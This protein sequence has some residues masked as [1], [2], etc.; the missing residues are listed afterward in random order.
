MSTKD[1]T[2][3]ASTKKTADLFD[4]IFTS[5]ERLF[6]R[7]VWSEAD[8]IRSLQA[9]LSP[10][11]HDLTLTSTGDEINAKIYRLN[12]DGLL[13]RLSTGYIDDPLE[14]S[15]LMKQGKTPLSKRFFDTQVNALE[16][17]ISENI[18]RVNSPISLSETL[19][20]AS[21]LSLIEGETKKARE[22]VIASMVALKFPRQKDA[23]IE[24]YN[25]DLDK[26]TPCATKEHIDTFN[27][28]NQRFIELQHKLQKP[29]DVL[30]FTPRQK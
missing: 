28:I 21:K 20:D 5:T 24:L 19:L 8:I 22:G 30:P 15:T 9:V 29:A 12:V 6:S 14:I 2:D 27:D 18:N 3:A 10:I 1:F 26:P 25:N 23:I 13:N 7:K 17:R 11:V 4:G 16:K